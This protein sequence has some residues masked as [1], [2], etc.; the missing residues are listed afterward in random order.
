MR[1]MRPRIPPQGA[2]TRIRSDPIN[3]GS[4][5]G[6]LCEELHHEGYAGIGF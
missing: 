2:S 6:V 3:P 1:P 5:T 4:H